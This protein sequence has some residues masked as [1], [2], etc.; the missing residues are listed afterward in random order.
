MVEEIQVLGETVPVI[1]GGSVVWIRELTDALGGKDLLENASW[2]TI[3]IDEGFEV[4]MGEGKF[5]V[6]V[7]ASRG[8]VILLS[9]MV[10]V[11][12]LS[13]YI[14]STLIE[15]SNGFVGGPASPQLVVGVRWLDEA[16]SLLRIDEYPVKGSAPQPRRFSA[17]LISPPKATYAEVGFVVT[18]IRNRPSEPPVTLRIRSLK[19]ME[20]PEEAKWHPVLLST[21]DGS[22]FRGV[23]RD[24]LLELQLEETSNGVRTN[25]SITNMSPLGRAVE[26]GV[27]LPINAEGWT[28]WGGPRDKA[29]I[30]GDDELSNVVNSLCSWGYLPISLYPIAAVENGSVGVHVWVPLDRPVI[31]RTVYKRGMGL[32]STFSIGLT[33][34]G[35]KH[36]FESFLVGFSPSRG[37]RDAIS[38]YYEEHEGWFTSRFRVERRRANW[39]YS[40]YGVWFAQVSVLTN[41]SAELAAVMRERGIHV[42]HYV[43]PWEFQPKTN[44]SVDE[45]P[46]TY[47]E[48]IGAMENMSMAEIT[49]KQFLEARAAVNAAA[50]D[51]NGQV[52]LA[53][54]PKGPNWRPNEW[55]PSI[56]LNTDPGLRGYNVWNY[57]LELLS[58]AQGL[59]SER[60]SSL[61]GVEL[62]N[63]MERTR[64]LD[65]RWEALSSSEYALTYD[66]N[67]FRPAVHLAA[68]AVEYLQELKGWVSSN[69]GN[70]TLSGNF[71]SEGPASFG[72]IYLDALPFECG[73]KGFNW[74]DGNLSYRRF[75]A[76]RKLVVAVLVDDLDPNDPEDLKLIEEF[77]N[78]SVFYGFLPT[79]KWNLVNGK[80]F[81]SVLG[82]KLEKTADIVYK[83][84]SLGWEPL[85]L[86]RSSA[87]EVW[88]ERFGSGGE[89]YLTVMNT[90]ERSSE[91]N[92][93]I[94]LG[95]LGWEAVYSADI[96]WGSG[97]VSLTSGSEG[98][99]SLRLPAGGVVV[100][101]VGGGPKVVQTE[102]ERTTTSIPIPHTETRTQ[103][104]EAKRSGIWR[105]WP[106]LVIGVIAAVAIALALR[107][108]RSGGEL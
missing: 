72:A 58:Y 97:E 53:R 25:L 56:P 15:S 27:F 93:T 46:P 43:L 4:A 87:E 57:T 22:S 80:S 42:V 17:E 91:A 98:K 23:W 31:F 61:D 60:N 86:V 6:K 68:P 8:K 81:E 44:R 71:I 99:I 1:K 83:V 59:M 67:A 84:N 40:R 69:I 32:G 13:I 16:G 21:A 90:E 48:I 39:P 30:G 11:N 3:S 106:F 12:N 7:N 95:A 38:S 62:D 76:G 108:R 36:S 47:W 18:G 37:F 29:Q 105:W 70:G 85:T 26:V 35:T 74:G 89:I 94:D 102:T 54:M 52:Q 78:A 34:A 82:E 5:E 65:H 75:L 101:R 19:F 51:E 66:P 77:I 92:L 96:A 10:R 14:L 49:Q 45:P 88:V 50:R 100:L 103:E 107:R 28:W 24:L 79:A 9:E 33:P 64:A 20:A 63:F 55:V 41:R 73:P 2:R 104:K